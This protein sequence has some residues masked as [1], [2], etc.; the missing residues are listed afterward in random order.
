M[1]GVLGVGKDATSE[2][3]RKAYLAKARQL[4]PDK[5]ATGLEDKRALAEAKFKEVARAYD[6][7]KNQDSRAL[8]DLGIQ[9]GF[10][11]SSDVRNDA[12]GSA[13]F[14]SH[15]SQEEL[16]RRNL[17]LTGLVMVVVA[18]GF[19]MA[20]YRSQN[21]LPTRSMPHTRPYNFDPNAINPATRELDASALPPLRV[22]QMAP[23]F[24]RLVPAQQPATS[25]AAMQGHDDKANRREDLGP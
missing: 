5:F 25:K 16:A 21:L 13:G 9:S 24:Q 8:Y 17:Q 20:F 6:I 14:A 10:A 4:H 18:L 19:G 11:S 3:L 15:A 7:L 22:G 23:R 1:Y 12:Y 2:D